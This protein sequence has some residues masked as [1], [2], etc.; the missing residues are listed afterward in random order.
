MICM[1]GGV[2]LGELDYLIIRLDFLPLSWSDIKGH[3]K[4]NIKK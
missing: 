2:K 4:I 3:M 1:L